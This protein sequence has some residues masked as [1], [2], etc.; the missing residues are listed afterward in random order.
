MGKDVSRSGQACGD[1]TDWNPRRGLKE[2][3]Q[4]WGLFPRERVVYE[5]GGPI[6]LRDP[7][8][9]ISC[10]PGYQDVGHWGSGTNVLHL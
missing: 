1:R 10:S 5:G 2:K 6:M 4:H 8:T 7:H 9:Q 3:Q